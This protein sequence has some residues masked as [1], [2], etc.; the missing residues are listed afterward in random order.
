[1]T[2]NSVFG[3]SLA[4]AA[5]RKTYD[6]HKSSGRSLL[7]V[8]GR[9]VKHHVYQMK[10]TNLRRIIQ[11]ATLRCG[12]CRL[13]ATILVL[14]IVE[15]THAASPEQ[16]DDRFGVPNL[17]SPPVTIDR[18][19]SG[20]VA[21]GGNFS[22][23]SFETGGYL[24]ANKVAIWDGRKWSRTGT[25]ANH[26]PGGAVRAVKWI[27]NDLYVGG[28]FF[29][30]SGTPMTR[31]ARWDGSSWHMLLDGLSEGVNGEVYSLA[32]NDS[33]LYVGG[34][35]TSAAGKAANHI[36]RWDGS[37]WSQLGPG[38]YGG[39]NPFVW[40]IAAASDG[41]IYAGGRFT[42]AGYNPAQSI[43]RW[44][45]GT[46]YP[47]GGSV[48]GPDPI[49]YAIAVAPDGDVVVGGNFTTA[50]GNPASNLAIWNGTSW[51]ELGN[52]VAGG[53][54]RALAFEGNKLWV[55]GTFD[56]VGGGQPIHGLATLENGVWSIPGGDVLF[57][58][59][60][61]DVNCI[62]STPDGIYLAG[63]F[64][65]AGD[66]TGLLGM[67]FWDGT[68][69]H[70]LHHGFPPGGSSAHQISVAG[71]HVMLGGD[72]STVGGHNT[73]RIARWDGDDW[74]VYGTPSS[75]GV[76]GTIA[77]A[78]NAVAAAPDG[79]GYVGGAFSQV[80]GIVAQNAAHWDGAAW[81]P[82]GSGV[83]GF[84]NPG[85]RALVLADDGNLYA[86]GRFTTAGGASVNNVAKWD[87]ANWSP[88]ADGLVY[89]SDPTRTEVYAL[90]WSGDRLY[91][92]GFFDKS[93]TLTVNGI[94]WWDG[95]GWHALDGGVSLSGSIAVVE[96]LAVHGFDVFAGGVFDHAGTTPA[97]DIAQWNAVDGW[98]NLSEGFNSSV[99]SVLI[100]GQ[101]LFAAG[102]FNQSGTSPI[103][104][105]AEW[106][107]NSWQGAGGLLAG[108]NA[109]AV[110]LAASGTNLYASG[111][112]QSAGDQVSSG[113]GILHLSNSPPVLTWSNPVGNQ[114]VEHGSNV[115]LEVTASDIDGTIVQVQFF[116]EGNSS[117]LSSSTSAPWQFEWTGTTTGRHRIAARATDDRGATTWSLVRNI[118]VLPP[119][120]DIRPQVAIASPADNATFKATTN[121]LLSAEASDAD[122]SVVQVDFYSGNAPLGTVNSPPWEMIWPDLQAGTYQLRAVAW[123]N[124]GAGATS[125]V[126][127]VTVL[128]PNDAPYLQISDPADGATIEEPGSY[129][130]R[131]NSSDGDGG[132]TSVEFFLNDQSV[133]NFTTQ[134]GNWNF[135]FLWDPAPPGDYIFKVIA[136][137]T[138][139]ATSES[140]THFVITPFNQPPEISMDGPEDGSSISMPNSI[141]LTV[142]ATDPDGEIAAVTWLNGDL[143]LGIKTNSPWVFSLRNLAATT[144]YLRARAVDDLGK[145]ATTS[146][147]TITVTNDPAAQPKYVLVDLNIPGGYEGLAYDVNNANQVAATIENADRNARG[148]RWENG[149]YT[150]IGN[151]I[152]PPETARLECLGI[153]DKGNVVGSG[154]LNG[155]E[156]AFRWDGQSLQQLGVLGESYVSGMYSRARAINSSDWVVGGSMNSNKIDRAFLY[157]D[158]TMSDLGGIDPGLDHSEAFDI[159]DKGHVVG[160][161][162]GSA[163]LQAFVYDDQ[164]GMQSLG[165]IAGSTSSSAYAINKHDQVVGSFVG[166]DGHLNAFLWSNGFNVILGTLGGLQSEALG[167]NNRGQVVG[168]AEN[169]NFRTRAFL[170]ENCSMFDLNASI[171]NTNW[172]LRS[173]VAINDAGWIV[174]TGYR[175]F[176]TEKRAFLLI[177]DDTENPHHPYSPINFEHGRFKMCVPVPRGT[178]YRLDATAN[179]KTWSPVST[180]Y[181]PEGVLDF[182]D[183]NADAYP[184]RFYRAVLLP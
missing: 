75:N 166:E 78:V 149:E 125:A 143:V 52:G 59:G 37:S 121:R 128:P 44:A 39:S 135:N 106:D 98:R 27:G 13:L 92:G 177:P 17:N 67:A 24:N 176:K 56:T 7:P 158:G 43:A 142:N 53:E 174:G 42:T 136:T 86:A 151:T 47:V 4:R 89:T 10:A 85:V 84:N 123:D 64:S 162:W 16:W 133:T 65:A 152:T 71:D 12:V 93:G 66:K 167:I 88:L 31:I 169:L 30:V 130:L 9:N 154:H 20:N 69:F 131:A 180:N 55:G 46:W 150:D 48:G 38:V 1:M 120:D 127:N 100:H 32:E 118:T 147:R 145:M 107:G 87:G 156:M 171:T 181:V 28:D 79:S 97:A 11:I 119:A 138:D 179:F 14:I 139:G 163:G 6:L 108:D 168:T 109:Y 159:N 114:I 45:N 8:V 57:G 61:G 104:G 178:T 184:N 91:A 122:G 51:A 18:S 126:V 144:Y 129:T 117:P 49:V 170:W 82:L 116:E 172:E 58:T 19:S 175:D 95:T 146:T 155:L 94:A 26:G 141:Q 41:S 96:A 90:A 103:P 157:R 164:H 132:L 113:F 60:S 77:V 50:G 5:R 3:R 148:F 182:R 22:G 29:A 2:T 140:S 35:F 62:K 25:G 124:L 83:T 165:I 183:P 115:P 72:F 40:A 36:A 81:E 134:L 161:A 160:R 101:R 76:V 15:C 137:D 68:A 73:Q 80:A 102:N 33:Q 21:I 173:A 153:N 74:Q 63:T 70:A 110:A 54:V 34:A 112:F 111:T 105:F 23:N 99:S